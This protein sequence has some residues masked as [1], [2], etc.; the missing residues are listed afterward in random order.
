MVDVVK[1]R[2]EAYWARVQ[3]DNFDSYNGL[4]FYKITV[5][6]DDPSWDKYNKSGFLLVPKGVS[7]DEE[8][9]LGVTFRRNVEPKLFKDKKTGKITEFGGGA[10]KVLDENDEPYEGLIGNGSIVEV[11]VAKFPVK[12]RKGYGHRLEKVKILELVNYEPPVEDE[13][14]EDEPPFKP[15]PKS[16]SGARRGKTPF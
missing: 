7:K 1:L 15:E 9:K 3:E 8:D 10:P 2:G 4:D 13:E 14:E 5:A 12:M 6:L 11:T 16:T